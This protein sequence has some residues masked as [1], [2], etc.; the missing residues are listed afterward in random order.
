MG[1]ALRNKWTH[2]CSLLQK[3]NKWLIAFSGGCDSALL[4]AAA[5]RVRGRDNVLAVTAVSASLPARERGAAEAL[6][7]FLDVP[8]RF[9]ETEELGNPAYAANPSNR[10]FFCKDELF[11]RLAPIADAAGFT[12]ADGFNASD[13]SD[14]RPGFQAA[15][16]WRVRH[17]LDDAGLAKKEVRCLSR[18][19]KLPTWD[20]PA[21]PCLSSR[22]P[23]GTPVSRATLSQIEQA[24][25]ALHAEG[26][27]VV[28]VRH[29]GPR[30]RIEVPLADLKRLREPA[31]WARVAEA[32][33]TAG[34]A[35]VEADPRGFQSGRLNEIAARF[36]T[37]DA[38]AYEKKYF[39]V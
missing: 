2:L 26:F 13:R 22:I 27:T 8:H 36:E 38:H 9:V 39:L 21:S 16:D 30:A 24:E 11:G 7:A 35:A 31:R 33:K 10:C 23:Y 25:D 19:L 20:K 6:A 1:L 4:L 5:R 18:W 12:L 15:Q 29:F 32:L 37:P 34:Y 28:R 3:E 14:V 17:P